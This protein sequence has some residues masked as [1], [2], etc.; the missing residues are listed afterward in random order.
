MTIA[1]IAIFLAGIGNFAMHRWLLEGAHPLVEAATG[2]LRRT[3]GRHVTYGLEFFLLLGAMLLS[4]QNWFI[5]L[6]LY[7][8]YTALNAA[9]IA[10]LKGMDD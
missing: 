9:T 10:W 4:V 6:C 2:P 7:G 1:L 8:V 3:F 5:A